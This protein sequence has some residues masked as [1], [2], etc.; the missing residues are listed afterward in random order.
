VA[1]RF[2]DGLATVQQ[3]GRRYG[4]AMSLAWADQASPH[5]AQAAYNCLSASAREAAIMAA[6][7]IAEAEA[8]ER[9]VQAALLR[10]IVAPFRHAD[11]PPAVLAWGDG[12]LPKLA[13]AIYEERAFD[14]LP[15][16]ADAL[17]DAGGDEALIA[18]LR[19]PGP[20]ARG[21]W[22]VDLLLAKP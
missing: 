14:R 17:E 3:R 13:Q 15:I 9:P 5:G 8:D 22:V 11:L 16:L 12:T 7:C 21:C 10:D 19:S 2:A 6:H 20:H 4:M 18:H 1:E